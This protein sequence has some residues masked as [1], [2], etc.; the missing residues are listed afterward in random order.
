MI[1][2]PARAMKR[3]PNATT[4]SMYFGVL[5]VLGFMGFLVLLGKPE[6]RRDRAAARPLS[7]AD[8]P[9]TLEARRTGMSLAPVADEAD[10][11][12][13]DANGHATVGLQPVRGTIDQSEDAK[14]RPSDWE[15]VY[16][17]FGLEEVETAYAILAR[18]ATDE[19]ARIVKALPSRYPE[20]RDIPIEERDPNWIYVNSKR[21]GEDIVY[22][23]PPEEYGRYYELRA[24]VQYLDQ[25]RRQLEKR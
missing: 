22:A 2:I 20:A 8:S 3:R 24:Q 5:I 25:R 13:V 10:D 21:R 1:S 4:Y 23:L 16:G 7:M 19:F 18:R 12:E 6:L 15:A 9:A 17:K 11:S 14:I